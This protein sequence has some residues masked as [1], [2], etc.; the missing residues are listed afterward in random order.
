MQVIHHFS[1]NYIE[2]IGNYLVPA[3]QV[4]SKVVIEVVKIVA[5]K[6]FLEH[7]GLSY[8]NDPKKISRRDVYLTTITAPLWEEIIFRFG[9]LKGIHAIQIMLDKS[10]FKLDSTLFGPSDQEDV[11]A[12]ENT[13][14]IYPPLV[15]EMVFRGYFAVVKLV[16]AVARYM[17]DHIYIT[18]SFT[19]FESEQSD[20][21]TIQCSLPLE[22][23]LIYH[24]IKKGISLIELPLDEGVELSEEQKIQMVFRVHLSALIF[25]SAHLSNP[26]TTKAQALLQFVWTYLGGI[27]YGYLTEKYHSLAPSIIMHGINNSLATASA[28]YSKKLDVLVIALIS[29]RIFGYMLAVTQIDKIVLLGLDQARHYTLSLPQRLFNGEQQEENIMV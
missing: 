29:N 15:E 7:L 24:V 11:Q 17:F 16:N 9:V 14:I 22:C 2:P 13:I 18:S 6:T 12:T 20:V 26:H 27:I 23:D 19:F 10:H 5:A 28:I 4:G 21:F 1:K 8:L 3:M 25:A